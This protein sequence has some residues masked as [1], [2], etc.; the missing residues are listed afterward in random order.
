M[1]SE[2]LPGLEGKA[3]KDSLIRNL[4]DPI[5]LSL[6]GDRE[7]RQGRAMTEGEENKGQ[8]HITDDLA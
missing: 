5:G 3:R 4:G 2:R 7:Q 1:H 6:S 8:E